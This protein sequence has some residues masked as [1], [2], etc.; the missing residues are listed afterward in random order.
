MKLATF[1]VAATSTVQGTFVR[2]FYLKNMSLEI[3]DFQFFEPEII[4]FNSQ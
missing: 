4:G 2:D 3:T 1:F